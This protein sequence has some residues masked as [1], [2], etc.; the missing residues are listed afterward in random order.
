MRT[1]Y[2]VFQLCVCACEKGSERERESVG[3]FAVA[4]S[5][6]WV[7][8]WIWICRTVLDLVEERVV[9]MACLTCACACVLCLLPRILP[10]VLPHSQSPPPAGQILSGCTCA[11]SGIPTNGVQQNLRDGEKNLPEHLQNDSSPQHLQE[12]SLAEQRWKILRAPCIHTCTRTRSLSHTL[13]HTHTHARAHNG[14][15]GAVSPMWISH[16][17]HMPE[18][19]RT[20]TWVMVHTWIRHIAR[21]NESYRAQGR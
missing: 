1:H 15:Q 9:C 12:D 16:V 10:C 18:S 17:T 4:C 6:V 21:I 11:E 3:I 20:Y 8:V 14:T 19:W 2:L 5:C 7:R 13:T